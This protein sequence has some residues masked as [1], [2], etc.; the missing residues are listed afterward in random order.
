MAV[1]GID[2]VEFIVDDLQEADAYLLRWGLDKVPGS[3]GD[4]YECADGSAVTLVDRKD[5]SAEAR[6]FPTLHEITWGVSDAAALAEL[7]AA[8]SP[9]RPVT[10]D[11]DGT[12]HFRDAMGLGIALRVTRKRPLE[13][14]P[15]LFNT[16]G[17]PARIDRSAAFY[18][19]AVP[20]EI[21]HSVLGGADLAAAERFYRERLGFHVS[22]RY[23]GRG[24]FLRAPAI[25]HHHNLFLLDEG[26]FSFNHL[27]FKV[28]DIHE[29]IGGGQGLARKGAETLVGPGRHYASSGCF[30]YFKSPFGGAL[31]YVADEDGVTTAW[32]PS[33]LIPSPERFSEWVFHTGDE[34]GALAKG[35]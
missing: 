25:G 5:V 30:W 32:Q 20:Q 31:E 1:V 21:G 22:D 9:E 23:V 7:L 10:R 19:R 2:Q 28:R 11:D 24:V 18:D 15:T 6:P 8:L 35:H 33:D 34:M 17:A 26:K 3:P 4:R 27:A 29:V 16:P 13:A 12:A 14:T